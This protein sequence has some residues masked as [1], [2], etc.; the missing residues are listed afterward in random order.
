MSEF[1]ALRVLRR[2][3]ATV[4]AGEESDPGKDTTPEPDT[5]LPGEGEIEDSQ[6]PR[7]P[8]EPEKQG[9]S[10][11]TD[12]DDSEMLSHQS[13]SQSETKTD[14]FESVSDT[15]SFSGDL[16][17][18]V[19]L[20]PSG[21]SVDREA[22]RRCPAVP[23]TRPPQEQYLTHVPGLDAKE[24][25]DLPPGLMEETREN[26]LQGFAAVAGEDGAEYLWDH[27]TSLELEPVLAGDPGHAGCCSQ[28]ALGSSSLQ[29]AQVMTSEDLRRLSGVSLQ[30]SRSESCLGIP[31][32][33]PF[34]LWCCERG[35]SWP[36]IHNRARAP[37]LPRRDPL[38]S[39]APLGA[40]T[41]KG[42]A[43]GPAVDTD[44]LWAQSCFDAPCWPP[45]GTS[46]LL[47][48]KCHHSAPENI[49]EKGTVAPGHCCQ[50]TRTLI[51]AHSIT[52][53]PLGDPEGPVG[54]NFVKFGAHLKEGTENERDPRTQNTLYSVSTQL[55][56]LLSASQSRGPSL[57]DT[58][59]KP[60]DFSLKRAS[61]DTSSTGLWQEDQLG[62]DSGSCPA[63]SCLT[64]EL[65]KL[66]VE[67]VP[68]PAECKLGHSPESS[69][70]ELLG[71]PL[72]P[73][74][75][76]VREKQKHL[77]DVSVEAGNQ[78]SNYTSKYVL[79]EK[80]KLPTRAK[81]PRRPSTE[82]TQV[83]NG[84]LTGCSAVGE[85][86]DAPESTPKSSA[87]DAS[88]EAEEGMVLDPICKKNALQG[89]SE[90]KAGLASR[91][92]CTVIIIAVEQK[93]LQATK[94]KLGPLP[95]TQSGNFAG[96]RLGSPL[97]TGAS[98][99]ASPRG[100]KAATCRKERRPPAAAPLGADDG[101]RPPAA[102]AAER[103][104]VPVPRP[105]LEEAPST[106][107]PPE[108][109]APGESLS[110][111][112]Q[113]AHGA[114]GLPAAGSRRG[115]GADAGAGQAP[116]GGAAGAAE[117]GP[118][119]SASAGRLPTVTPSRKGRPSAVERS[120]ELGAERPTGAGPPPR[121]VDR[122]AP[123]AVVPRGAGAGA[124][125]L[126]EGGDVGTPGDPGSRRPSSESCSAKRLRTTEK[127]LRA[128]LAL[129]HKTFSNF[130]ESKVLEKENSDERSPGSPK[131]EKR[132]RLRQSSWRAFLKGRDA[133]GPKRPPLVTLLP[134]PEISSRPVT[135]SP[136]K[137][138][139]EDKD[140][141]VFGDHW[142]PPHPPTPLSSSSLVSPE[143]RRRSEPSIKCTAPQEGGRY[144]PPGIVP[145]KPW[146]TSPASPGAQQAGIR[147]TLPSSSACCLAFDSPRIPCRPL[148]PKPLG[149]RYSGRGNAISMVSLGS[150]SDVDSS[151]GAPE[152]PKIP[153]ARTSLLLS[154]QTLNQD[155][156]KEER[157][158]RGQC[159]SGLSTAPSL[160]DVPGSEVSS[161][162]VLWWVHSR[163][164]YR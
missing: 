87:V 131:G 9:W 133:E 156:Q 76:D 72:A 30:K 154:L 110:P 126:T 11:E 13:E 142:V 64:S 39:T 120:E 41:K 71:T 124:A 46:C 74:A 103:G 38:D 57:Q 92:G 125:G 150:Y 151:S 113:G 58:Y 89:L 118:R 60:S 62:Q 102:L 21:P 116:G 68:G 129:A 15:E 91:G 36:H 55:S 32:V 42:R 63:A 34:L 51:R 121:P 27:V 10:Q 73:S 94:K 80:R 149:L 70:Q 45:L 140:G 54:Q 1:A 53:F 153:K 7:S 139:A 117:S 152:R 26:V 12:Q 96:E 33:W 137:E 37:V 159:P 143:H 119:S 79:S 14:P 164:G 40:R 83:R 35:R 69:T 161:S 95:E 141:C 66:S 148:S 135:D 47:H 88:K 84:V 4:H 22:C 52:G 111:R 97:S 50:H 25:P 132:N 107:E 158:K 56:H 160:R 5:H 31:V 122:T 2:A 138:W 28:G 17:R 18:E 85:S 8:A 100:R 43:P 147:R 16:P 78:T 99:H 105:A 115:C 77:Y 127:R 86:A 112:P 20:P 145:E 155:D 130:F 48:A 114:P 24:E 108:E 93:G 82:G 90:S 61:Q 109:K 19:C 59:N 44:L 101:A 128:R 29:P 104:S 157:R 134:G 146:L 106:E 163:E 6:L 81:F 162:P 67:E 144:L 3:T 98:P 49:G 65:V 136:C 123:L 75:A 23:A